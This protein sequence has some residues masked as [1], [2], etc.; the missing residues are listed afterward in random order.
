V[1]TA[2]PVFQPDIIDY[3]QSHILLTHSFISHR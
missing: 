1:E 3:R 2:E